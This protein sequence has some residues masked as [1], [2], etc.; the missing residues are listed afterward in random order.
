[1][2]RLFSS[3]EVKFADGAETSE[4]QGY[5]SVFNIV[6]GHGDK[7]VPGAFAKTL[8]EWEKS[9]ELPPMLAQHGGFTSE[10]MTPIGLWTEL[11]EDSRGL[12]CKGLLAPTP[13]G[14]GIYALMKMQPRP[15]ISGVSIGFWPRKFTLGTKPSEPRRVLEEID[16]AEISIVTVPANLRARA[17]AVKSARDLTIREFETA[18]ERGTLPPLSSSEAKRLLS[19]GFKAMNAERDAGD[20]EAAELARRFQALR[21]A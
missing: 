7:I 18:L 16:L 17:S 14:Q 5:A 9:G 2:H 12:R 19:G 11:K 3:L 8:A 10:D 13:R 15:A 4:I 21:G 20:D 6:D 1:M